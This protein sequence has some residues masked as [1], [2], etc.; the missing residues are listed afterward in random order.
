MRE[1]RLKLKSLQDKYLSVLDQLYDNISDD[2]AKG[3]FLEKSLG[4]PDVIIK[5]WALERV[6]EWRVASGTS[7]LPDERSEE[8]VH[9]LFCRLHRLR[10]RR[11]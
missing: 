1:M 2:T 6:R 10:F 8:L 3:K 11:K 5:L 9:T 7:K 4:G